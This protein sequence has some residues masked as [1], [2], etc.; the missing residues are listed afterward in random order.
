[1]FVTAMGAILNTVV[2]LA[3]IIDPLKS[4]RKGPWITL[5]NLAIADIITC[6]SAFCV[7]GSWEYFKTLYESKL[8]HAICQFGWGFGSSAS[9]LML[10]LFTAQIYVVTKYPLKSRYI[11]TEAKMVFATLSVWLFSFFLG[12]FNIAYISFPLKLSLKLYLISNSI[13]FAAVI[14]QV[15]LNIRVTLEILRSGRCTGNDSCQN[16]KHRNIAK[17]VI[18][19]TT[20]LFFTAFPYFVLKQFEYIY[21]MGYLGQSYTA[22]MSAKIYHWY[23]PIGMVNFAANPILYSLRLPDYKRTLLFF[24]GMNPT[25]TKLNTSIK[26]TQI[27]GF[28]SSSL[29][30]K[31]HSVERSSVPGNSPA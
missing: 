28:S 25:K 27:H 15:V 21:R 3:V 24:V 7:F 6:I 31:R 4:L 11:F 8:Y 26:L 30:S 9:F 19:L 5:L 16:N 1:M 10:T 2:I 18:L 20:I 22:R 13:L 17:T 12:L 14:T 29:R 23:A